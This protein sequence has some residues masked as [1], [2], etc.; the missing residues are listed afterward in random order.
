MSANCKKSG[1]FQCSVKFFIAVAFCAFAANAQTPSPTTPG[2]AYGGDVEIKRPA[3]AAPQYPSPVTFTDITLQTGINFKHNASPTSVKY[4]P[5]TMSVGV[6]MFDFDDDGWTDVF[7]ANDNIDRQLFCNK[8]NGTFEESALV[9]GVAF[10]EKGKR[11]AG[12]GVDAAN[13][14]GDGFPDLFVGNYG[15]SR[16]YHN[17][18]NGTFTDV[19]PRVNLD[20]KGWSTGATF[21]DYDKDGRLDIFV[22]QY[23]DYDLRNLPMSPA[24]AGKGNALGR[25][26]CQFR[27]Q[28]VM[29]GP[30]N[31][32][33]LRFD[34]RRELRFAKRT[35]R[36]RRIGRRGEN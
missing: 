27:G 8:R 11:F 31:A 18:G 1:M 15:T 12:M 30:Q 28:P 4:L 23:L 3:S 5:E 26:F 35:N 17:N 9:A 22:P 6:A 21:G 7:V 32:P 34:K 20:I 33:A 36:P 13:F 19:A 16:L 29:C 24:D 2:K 14:D 25:N 10:D